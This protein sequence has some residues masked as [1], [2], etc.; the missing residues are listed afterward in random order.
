MNRQQHWETVY[1]T[2]ATTEVS[3]YAQHLE[4]SLR[5][6]R[7]VAM[8]GSH[9]IDIGGGAATLVDDLLAVGY[10]HLT[11]LDISAT[12]L[13]KAK[14]R[15]GDKAAQVRWLKA[16]I[17]QASLP[18]QTYDVWH[19]RAVLHFLT[20]ETDRTAYVKNLRASL[21]PG[22]HVIIGT[23]ALDGP[24]KCSGLDVKR[25]DAKAMQALLGEDF[26]LEATHTPVHITPA[27]KEQRF[28]VCRFR[29]KL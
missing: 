25:Y 19:D 8:P 29:R 17:T 22:G 14:Q 28:I 24:E 3:W 16:D 2:K 23:F 11:V 26:V 27:N 15:L 5:L 12:A 9:I 13:E 20:E 7:E 18:N 6:I 4:L 21:K 1:Q 10:Q